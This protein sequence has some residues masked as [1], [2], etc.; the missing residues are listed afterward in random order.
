VFVGG[1]TDPLGRAATWKDGVR[2]VVVGLAGNRSL[3]TGDA[4]RI[5]ELGLG[6]AARDLPGVGA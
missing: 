5:A 6:A 3:E 1:G 2:A 4:V